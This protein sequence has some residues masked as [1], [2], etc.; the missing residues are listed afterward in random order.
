VEK[1]AMHSFFGTYEYTLD[2]KNRLF[3]PPEFRAALKQEKA[4]HFMIASGFEDCLYLY[5][6]SQWGALLDSDPESFKSGDK[7]EVRAFKRFFFGS[8]GRAPVDGQGRVL[9]EQR[10]KAYAG[11]AKHVTIVGVGNKAEI[12]DSARWRA[13]SARQIKPRAARFGKIHDL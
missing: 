13:Y 12:W 3:L 2:P 5:L 1:R 7:Q 8:A 10:H 4:S 11:L 6:P 9:L